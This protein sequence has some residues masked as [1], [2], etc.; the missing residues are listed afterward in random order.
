VAQYFREIEAN[1]HQ[2]AWAWS[3][4]SFINALGHSKYHLETKSAEM[5]FGSR[6]MAQGEG[7]EAEE[8]E[9]EEQEDEEQESDGGDGGE[10]GG[11]GGA[12]LGAY[13][14]FPLLLRGSWWV[15]SLDNGMQFGRPPM[16]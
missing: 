4:D 8:Q 6:V 9:D 15:I 3:T 16:G 1:R 2:Q 14:R 7:G 12:G 11:G 13:C 5:R 10:G